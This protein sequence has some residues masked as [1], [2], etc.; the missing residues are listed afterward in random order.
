MCPFAQSR[1][2][3]VNAKRLGAFEIVVEEV[4]GQVFSV[5]QPGAVVSA[6]VVPI[7]TTSELVVE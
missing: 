6:I 7:P 1:V 3:V 5:Q 2:A 4:V